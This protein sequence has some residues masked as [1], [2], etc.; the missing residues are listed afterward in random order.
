MTGSYIPNTFDSL[1]SW[2]GMM[3][4]G[5]IRVLA[6]QNGSDMTGSEFIEAQPVARP[7]I[8]R[9]SPGMELAALQAEYQR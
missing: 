5:P 8:P 2:L 6:M 3:K 9:R 1:V 4:W 7:L